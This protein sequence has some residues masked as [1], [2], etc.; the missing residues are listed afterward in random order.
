M[1]GSD[2]VR[3]LN[4]RFNIAPINKENYHTFIGK[5]FDIIINANGNSKRYWANQN[6][7]EDF[8]ASTVS[9]M[10]SIFDFS[11]DL[12][13][14]ISSPDIYEDHQGGQN[15]IEDYNIDSEKLY[16]YG[17]HKYLSELIIKKYREKYIIL[18][19]SMIIGANLKKG[20]FFDI[21]HNNPLFISLESQ[22][23]LIT[24]QAVAEIINTLVKK[25]I[26]NETINVGGMGS[27]SFTK[28]QDFIYKKIQLSKAA[29]TQIYEMNVDRLKELYPKLK[30]SEEY[31]REFLNLYVI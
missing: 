2:L 14:Y 26:I 10:N 8:S 17:F 24:C 9:V 13:I 19:C 25:S 29:E 31:L 15:T 11:C 30:T 21:K 6:P 22:L 16:P 5:K 1:L 4:D 28:I 18:R 3:Y 20:P 12:Y 27:F 23:Q 7:V